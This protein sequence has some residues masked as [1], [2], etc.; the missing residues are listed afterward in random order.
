LLPETWR[1][2]MTASDSPRLS[3]GIASMRLELTAD[4]R[5]GFDSLQ[6]RLMLT[7]D[8][9]YLA[10][11]E[12]KMAPRHGAVDVDGHMDMAA[13][14]VVELI[15]PWLP[16]AISSGRISA[17]SVQGTLKLSWRPDRGSAGTADLKAHDVDLIVGSVNIEDA[18]LELNIGDIS[19]RSMALALDVQKLSL[20]KETTLRN[21]AV[22]A[23]I[24]DNDLTLEKATLPVFGGVVE[25]LPNTVILDQRPIHLTLGVQ[26][27]DLSQLLASLNYPALSGTGTISG[28]L[29]LRLTADAIELEGG[30]LEGTRPGVLQYQGPVSDDENLAFK[31]L[32][33]LVYH[34]LQAEVNYHPNGDYHLGLRLEGR[35]P[36][37]LSGHPLAF[38]LN[39]SGQLPELLRKGIREGDF[40]R[41]ILEQATAKP[42]NDSKTAKPLQSPQ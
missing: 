28:K 37:V 17:G 32:R 13:T 5:D 3:P 8:K 31:A 21:L 40:E 30:T 12:L 7:R 33:N 39:L 25:V 24:L 34:S 20:G 29:P 38:N 36:G 27:V 22:K 6:G 42:A 41:S 1:S 19:R 26:N 15:K 9:V 14:E 23:Q 16:E 10:S 35:N 2:K 11:A 18:D 4:T